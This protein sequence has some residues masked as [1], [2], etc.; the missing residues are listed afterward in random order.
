MESTEAPKERRIKDGHAARTLWLRMRTASQAR[1]ERWAQVQN[2]LDGAPPF[3]TAELVESGQGWRC[4]VNFRDASSTLEQVLVSY[5]RLLHDTTNLAAVTVMG[6]DPNAER[7]EQIF[8]ANF[9]R[10]NDD[11]G[12]DYVRNYLLFSQNHVAFGCGVAFWNDKFSPRWEAV[13]LGEIEVPSRAKASVEKLPVVGV[14]QELEVD[15]L[16]KL[17]RTPEQRKSSAERGWD[18]GAIEKLLW[19]ETVNRDSSK[20]GDNFG[21]ADVLEMQREMR[22]NSLGATAGND[23]Y[24]LFRDGRAREGFPVRRLVGRGSTR[25]HEPRARRRVLRRR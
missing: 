25:Q 11:W 12:A 2:Q 10:F 14:R 17:V 23:P 9:N 19:Y 6:E 15:E 7:W 1:R 13:R 16:W 5:W 3:A 18:V 4:N 24:D 8:Q 21:P 22:N 20:N